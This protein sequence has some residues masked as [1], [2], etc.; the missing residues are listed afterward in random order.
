MKRY[1]T[2]SLAISRRRARRCATSDSCGFD[3]LFSSLTNYS[4]CFPTISPPLSS[5]QTPVIVA[6]TCPGAVLLPF[7]DEDLVTSILVSFMPGQEYGNGLADLLV[8]KVSPS[9]RLAL[10]FPKVENEIQFTQK[11]WPGYREYRGARRYRE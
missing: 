2:R 9:G 11:Q 1:S 7:A 8:G 4:L 3:F 6:V 10:T 5:L